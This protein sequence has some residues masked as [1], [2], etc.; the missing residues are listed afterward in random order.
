MENFDLQE[1]FNAGHRNVEG[2]FIL[3]S[4]STEPGVSEALSRIKKDEKVRAEFTDILNKAMPMEVISLQNMMIDLAATTIYEFVKFNPIVFAFESTKKLELTPISDIGDYNKNLQRLMH[5]TESYKSFLNVVKKSNQEDKLIYFSSK[6]SRNKYDNLQE[7]I[8]ELI[9]FYTLAEKSKKYCFGE[10]ENF[11]KLAEL[12]ASVNKKIIAQ[13]RMCG[14]KVAGVEDFEMG[15][16][17]QGVMMFNDFAHEFEILNARVV[18]LGSQDKEFRASVQAEIDKARL[19]KS[20][21]E[22]VKSSAEQERLDMIEKANSL[23]D[24]L[25]LDFMRDLQ[26]Q[27]ALSSKDLYENFVNV[28]FKKFVERFHMPLAKNTSIGM[29][30]EACAQIQNLMNYVSKISEN[31]YVT[32]VYPVEKQ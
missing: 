27:Y 7:V 14:D 26:S 13:L 19:E 25:C 8:S 10:Y 6:D 24:E 5:A 32:S 1:F 22:P 17:E 9:K 28:K 15:Y 31:S 30:K 18:E 23:Y 4:N 11:S 20:K 12:T 16:A 21:V 2:I 29:A 3:L